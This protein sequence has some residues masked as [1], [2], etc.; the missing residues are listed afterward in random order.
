[1]GLAGGVTLDRALNCCDS[2]C[3]YISL[4]WKWRSYYSPFRIARK[5][6]WDNV[7]QNAHLRALRKN[8]ESVAI[9]TLSFQKKKKLFQ[10]MTKFKAVHWENMF[11]LNRENRKPRNTYPYLHTIFKSDTLTSN[12][13]VCSEN[14]CCQNFPYITCKLFHESLFL[15]QS[16]YCFHEESWGSGRG[17]PWDLEPEGRLGKK[18]L[19]MS[20]LVKEIGFNVRGGGQTWSQSI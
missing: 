2:F 5:M 18:L 20:F 3:D 15:G 9:T 4:L 8:S 10:M 19:Q 14:M 16:F 11:S 1:M 13:S 17:Q 12:F 7:G 6:N